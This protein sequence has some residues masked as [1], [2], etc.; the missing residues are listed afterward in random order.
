VVDVTDLLWT[1]VLC[2]GYTLQLVLTSMQQCYMPYGYMFSNDN[3]HVLRASVGNKRNITSIFEILDLMDDFEV[4]LFVMCE[5][6][7]DSIY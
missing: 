1:V 4:A 7:E 2:L 3:S 5:Y 6:E